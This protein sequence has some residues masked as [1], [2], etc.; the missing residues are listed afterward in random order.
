LGIFC[1]TGRHLPSFSVTPL[2]RRPSLTCGTHGP[3]NLASG[4]GPAPWRSES[5]VYSQWRPSHLQHHLQH[6][7]TPLL[8]ISAILHTQAPLCY[9]S[10]LDAKIGS[11]SSLEPK[12]SEP[13]PEQV[14]RSRL[15]QGLT[16]ALEVRRLDSFNQSGASQLRSPIRKSL[17]NPQNSWSPAP[18][19]ESHHIIQD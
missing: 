16:H 7:L 13:D 10:S 9:V 15:E 19:V 6:H 18:L 2:R 1:R 11:I 3:A 17:C 5:P 14:K 8:Y 4:S 12:R